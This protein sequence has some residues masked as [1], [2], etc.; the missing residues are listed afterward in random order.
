M[1]S[2]EDDPKTKMPEVPFRKDPESGTVLGPG[3]V[4][5]PPAPEPPAPEPEPEPKPRVINQYVT[6]KAWTEKVFQYKRP[7]LWIML[8]WWQWLYRD[9]HYV[10]TK[11][12]EEYADAPGVKF[13]EKENLSMTVGEL[14]VGET[15]WFGIQPGIGFDVQPGTTVFF[16]VSIPEHTTSTSHSEPKEPG[17]GG[18][19]TM[20]QPSKPIDTIQNGTSAVNGG[21]SPDVSG[22][23][24]PTDQTQAGGW[25]TTGGI[26]TQS[27]KVEG[28]DDPT[29]PDDTVSTLSSWKTYTKPDMVFT[30]NRPVTTEQAK[31]L[32]LPTTY[33][34][35]TH[36]EWKVRSAQ[37]TS[38]LPIVTKTWDKEE[39]IKVP[40]YWYRII[41]ESYNPDMYM[42]PR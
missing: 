15:T 27:I 20:V 33:P 35:G 39:H 1:P 12:W 16:S 13:N 9:V 14:Y 23:F 36:R 8:W 37:P 29:N 42:K 40:Y 31:A 11:E 34:D 24:T 7:I 6:M 18:D 38:N 25:D 17:G 19:H 10:Y 2:E 32:G 30:E 28:F 22:Q 21:S 3:Q 5:E 41:F 26:D 4:T